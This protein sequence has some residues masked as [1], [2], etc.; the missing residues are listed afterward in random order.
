MKTHEN[1]QTPEWAAL[2]DL[3][4]K[5]RSTNPAHSDD[6]CKMAIRLMVFQPPQ[7]FGL[8]YPRAYLCASRAWDVYAD[9]SGTYGD[10][11]ELARA[12]YTEEVSKVVKQT[13]MRKVLN[14]QRQQIEE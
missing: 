10:I 1:W 14:R 13:L 5:T 11:E 3:I 12:Y 4:L 8:N 6:L 2:K 7:F 9:N